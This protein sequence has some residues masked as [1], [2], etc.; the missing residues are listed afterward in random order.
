MVPSGKPQTLFFF[1]K[2]VLEKALHSL[3]GTI[4]IFSIRVKHYR[5]PFGRGKHH[6]PH[7]AFAVNL[8]TILDKRDL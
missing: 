2:L 4:L 6:D 3:H 1:P 8:E 5:A 7:D